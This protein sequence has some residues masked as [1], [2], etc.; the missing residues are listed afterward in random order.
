MHLL[1]A[2]FHIFG[3]GRFYGSN[4]PL[5]SPLLYFSI[6]ILTIQCILIIRNIFNGYEQ[7]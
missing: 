1:D 4:V 6:H 5:I 7:C 2:I 3:I